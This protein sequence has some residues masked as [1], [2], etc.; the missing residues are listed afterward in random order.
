MASEVFP[1][2]IH[3]LLDPIPQHVLGC[4][5]ALILIGASPTSKFAKKLAWVFRCIGCPFTGL[6]YSLNIGSKSE[7]LCIYWLSSDHFIID[8]RQAKVRP[9]GIHVSILSNIQEHNIERCVERCTARASVLEII[10]SF[11]S[12]YYIIISVI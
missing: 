8:E 5:P 2:V 1:Q 4:L 9:F 3:K 6:F 12:G 10:V 7:S 11:V